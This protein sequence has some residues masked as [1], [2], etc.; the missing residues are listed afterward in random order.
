MESGEEWPQT[1]VDCELV[2]KLSIP[3]FEIGAMG[4]QVIPPSQKMDNTAEHALIA[5]LSASWDRQP[6]LN[7][8]IWTVCGSLILSEG[9]TAGMSLILLGEIDRGYLLTGFVA[10][11]LASLLI[12]ALILTF[13][14]RLER[15]RLKAMEAQARGQAFLEAILDALPI[16]TIV[17]DES[18]R[19]VVVSREASAVLQKPRE[20]LLGRTDADVSPPEVAKL[21]AEEDARVMATGRPLRAEVQVPVAGGIT[22]WFEKCK[23]AVT[24]AD[25]TRFTIAST[26]DIDDRRR[27]EEALRESEAFLRAATWATDVRLWSWSVKE[28]RLHLAEPLRRRLGYTAEQLSDDWASLEALVHPDDREHFSESRRKALISRDDRCEQEF[29][30][31]HRDGHW[32]WILSRARIERDG[33]GN[34]VRFIGGHLDITERKESEAVVRDHRDALAHEVE[35]RTAELVA[36]RNA[37]EAANRAKSAFLANMSHE[38]RTP[39]HSVLSFSR[40]GLGT[41]ARGESAPEKLA[42]F[43]GNIEQSATRLQSLVDD[44]LDLAELETGT[45]RLELE[46]E[47]P[48]ILAA[49]VLEDMRPLAQAKRMDLVLQASL[50]RSPYL[51]DGT[52]VGQVLRQLLANAIRYSPE[53]T[54]VVVRVLDDAI[55]VGTGAREQALRIEVIDE[56]VGIAETELASV[57]DRFVEGSKTRSGAGGTGLGL[58]ICRLIVSLHG[59]LIRAERNPT[60]GTTIVVI[61]PTG[62]HD[63][64]A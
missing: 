48:R 26:L 18:G 25:G 33:E 60:R 14:V 6:P 5:R 50:A 30:I 41:A 38:L 7:R 36:A 54:T 2:P 32:V 3:G 28:D 15:E 8:I 31:R 4:A 19:F 56:G 53:D 43:F 20:A 11:V 34:A 62:G 57:F 22:R 12:S 10:S 9:I 63:P 52:R 64:E 17:K 45:V 37:A 27:A 59:G 13:D 46:P 39:L 40:L 49:T 35:L 51:L 42:R 58:A 1:E 44:L 24:L 47:D 23:S 29:R 61:L 55:S 21:I 16:P